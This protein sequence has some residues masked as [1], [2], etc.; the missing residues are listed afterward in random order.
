MQYDFAKSLL[1]SALNGDTKLP[2]AFTEL[3]FTNNAIIGLETMKLHLLKKA[4]LHDGRDNFLKGGNSKKNAIS[5]NL[6]ERYHDASSEALSDIDTYAI[7]RTATNP[8]ARMPDDLFKAM[9]PRH[10][11]DWTK[12]PEALRRVGLGYRK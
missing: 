1:L 3:V 9:E 7:N 2:D 5:I 4:A 11:S 6:S 12:I 8:E 10:R